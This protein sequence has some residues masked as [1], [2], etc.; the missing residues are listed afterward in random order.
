MKMAQE[1]TF[2]LWKDM[3]FILALSELHSWFVFFFSDITDY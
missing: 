2:S 1:T 3:L